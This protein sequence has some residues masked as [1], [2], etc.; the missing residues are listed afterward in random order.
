MGRVCPPAWGWDHNHLG[1]ITTTWVR[2]QLELDW[3]GWD[4]NQAPKYKLK[5]YEKQNRRNLRI[6]KNGHGSNFIFLL[7]VISPMCFQVSVIVVFLSLMFSRVSAMCLR[8]S[9]VLW[10]FF[11][12]P[13]IRIMSCSLIVR[14]VSFVFFKHMS[15]S[16]TC[17][18]CLLSFFTFFMFLQFLICF[19]HVL[20]SPSICQD[21]PVVLFCVPFIDHIMFIVRSMFC[22][23]R[24]MLDPN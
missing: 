6:W 3:F 24:F 8:R 18:S 13:R 7:V 2:S 20:S 23:S 21:F 16:L 9:F 12:S 22:H 1:E 15:F 19:L 14:Y 17:Q 11:R 10:M 5:N 4:H